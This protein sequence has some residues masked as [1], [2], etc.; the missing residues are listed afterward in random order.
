M[1]NKLIRSVLFCLIWLGCACSVS[2]LT[3]GSPKVI[4]KPGEPLRAEI[5]INF[6]TNE[7]AKYA[8]SLSVEIPSQKEYERLGISP[9]VLELNVL[10]GIYQ[11]TEGRLVV[12]VELSNLPPKSEDPFIDFLIKLN[13]TSGS[14]MK[15]FSMLIGDP[16]K[17]T[18]KSGQTLS[19]IAL[20]ISTRYDGATLDQAMM[21]LYKANPDA[22]ASGSIN[23]L[24]AGAN[25]LLPSQTLIR[26]ISP[27]EANH[28]VSKSNEH[29]LEEKKISSDKLLAD[30]IKGEK[31]ESFPSGQAKDQLKISSAIGAVDESRRYSEEIVAQE[32][33]LEQA[34]NRV[35]ELEKNITDLHRLLDKG[36]QKGAL[37]EVLGF[38]SVSTWGPALLAI[39]LMLV[40]G[41]LLYFLASNARRSD[42]YND[43]VILE[44]SHHSTHKD[45]VHPDQASGQ[46][47]SMSD[48]AKSLL[49]G[50]DLDL[51]KS[52]IQQQPSLDSL[53]V[54]FNLAR[55]YVTIED[56]TAAKKCLDEIL[57]SSNL[58]DPNL[59]IEARGLLLE[60][61]HRNQNA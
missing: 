56:F 33:M 19:E 7:K 27:I 49:A 3:L 28:F 24:A 32:K 29:W 4:S 51:P 18:V 38:G 34:R 26:S 45:L 55:A 9:R 35:A 20:Q 22:F 40:T 48:R 12:L 8:D 41:L 10:A 44:S 21:A 50:I 17:I 6:L 13:W 52:L 25:L 46:T 59:T 61:D 37:H 11:N 31:S 23:R 30:G 53:R 54:K 1:M 2:A 36:K 16:Q 5:P 43:P 39:G 60:I 47:P 58:V 14:M 57:R 42:P 15:N